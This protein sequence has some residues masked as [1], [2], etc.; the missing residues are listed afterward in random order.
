MDPTK[1]RG[2][3]RGLDALL[4][5]APV[6]PPSRPTVTGGASP[7]A[8]LAPI[9]ELHPSRSQ[10]RTR[11]DDKSLDELASSL[12]E[13]GMLEPILVR[14]RVGPGAKFRDRLRRAALRA[15]NAR[16]A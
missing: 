2:L 12:R 15:P 4:P 10:P 5:A 1:K 8:F 14:K 6:Q 11:F 13:L 7:I 3:G 16:S 9:E